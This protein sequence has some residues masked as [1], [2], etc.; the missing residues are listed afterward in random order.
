MRLAVLTSHPIQYYAPLFRELA[1]RIDL[2]VVYAHRSTPDQQ[3]A[4]GFG[5][6]FDWDVDLLSGYKYR[7]LRNVSKS[8][9]T[10]TFGGCDTPEIGDAIRGG[11]FDAVLVMG[12]HLKYYIQ[13]ILAS[14]RAGIPVMVRGDSQLDTPHLIMKRLAKAVSYPALL[15][16]F[17]A[18]LYVGKR[19]REYYKHYGVPNGR[20][21]HA[22]HCVD[23]HWFASRATEEV[24]RSLRSKLG[25]AP[26]EKVVLF[27]G[28][29]VDFKRPLDVVEAVAKV[30]ISKT[31]SLMLAGSGPLGSEIANLARQLGVRTHDLGF[32]NQS[33]MPAVYAASQVLALPSTGR[34]TWG[35]VCNEA[36]ACGRPIVVSDAVGCGPDLASDGNVGRTFELGDTDGLAE[37]IASTLRSPPSAERIEHI[38]EAFSITAAA[39]GIEEALSAISR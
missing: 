21:F 24:G 13:G 11:K 39:G 8:P 4:A 1:R 33:Q 30:A 6:A 31:V 14:K 17:D 28:K 9:G 20:L 12:W 19:N 10:Q 2:E 35:L 26:D 15:R 18:A 32:C 22:P 38:S 29:F 34:E 5:T 36:L 27:A 37:A 7:F 16:V 25:I 23:T 3:A